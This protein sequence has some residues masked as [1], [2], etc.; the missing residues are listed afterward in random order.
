MQMAG[1]GLTGPG[2]L[3]QVSFREPETHPSFLLRKSEDYSPRF[4]WMISSANAFGTSA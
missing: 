4:F 2:H 1:P 3:H